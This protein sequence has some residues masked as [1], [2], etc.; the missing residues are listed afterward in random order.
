MTIRKAE[1]IDLENICSVHT[2]SFD[3]NHFSSV[4]PKSLLLGFYSELLKNND[5]NYVALDEEKNISGF[6]VAGKNTGSAIDN[7]IRK[8][9]KPLFFILL[10]NPGFLF[11]KI[12]V[13][14]KKI[15]TK[16]E[17]KSK[18]EIRL[19]SIAV[20][21][22]ASNR[23]IGTM[24]VRY[25]EEELIKN[26]IFIYGLSVRKH[27]QNAINFYLKNNFEVEKEF[28]SAIYFLKRLKQDSREF[29]G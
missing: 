17:F 7:F 14:L 29:N 18:A 11:Q 27:N 16:N 1:L 15:F 6:I 13:Y 8:S 20:K 19:L 9:F 22:D 2:Y 21:R 5:F 26:G 28:R 23:G 10:K 25:F 24:L 12:I 3:K 4:L